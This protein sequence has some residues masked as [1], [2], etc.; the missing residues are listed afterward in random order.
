M[1]PQAHNDLSS[2]IY[3]TSDAVGLNR[4]FAMRPHYNTIS[5]AITDK[6]TCD[7]GSTATTDV[8]AAP[9][10][11]TDHVIWEEKLFSLQLTLHEPKEFEKYNQAYCMKTSGQENHCNQWNDTWTI[12]AVYKRI[13]RQLVLFMKGSLDN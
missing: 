5:P 2:G 6:I 4:S 9:T 13:S 8:N 7:M 1:A 3:S 11:A 12:S 10:V